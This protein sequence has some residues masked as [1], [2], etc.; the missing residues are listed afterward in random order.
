[1]TQGANLR[2]KRVPDGGGLRAESFQ[3]RSSFHIPDDLRSEDSSKKVYSANDMKVQSTGDMKDIIRE[4]KSLLSSD[5]ESFEEERNRADTSESLIGR[6]VLILHRYLFASQ[7]HRLWRNSAPLVLNFQFV[8]F[9]LM[10]LY[11]LLMVAK[12]LQSL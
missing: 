9:K 10:A 7:L 12:E 5:S 11:K 6:E 4:G 2:S 1:M 3:T 8:E